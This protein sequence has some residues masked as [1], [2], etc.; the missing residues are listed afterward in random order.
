[1]NVLK[2]SNSNDVDAKKYSRRKN[3]NIQ[4]YKT[5]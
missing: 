2:D 1:M 5:K 4:L 3:A